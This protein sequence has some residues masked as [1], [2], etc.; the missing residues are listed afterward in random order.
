MVRLTF[1]KEIVE[2]LRKELAVAEKLNNLHLYKIVTCLL[3]IQEGKHFST[4]AKQVNICCRTVY[5]WLKK[6]MVRGFSWLLGKHYKG[7]GRKPQWH[8]LKE[9]HHSVK[10]PHQSIEPSQATGAFQINFRPSIYTPSIYLPASSIFLRK[11]G[12]VLFFDGSVKW[13]RQYHPSHF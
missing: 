10:D 8:S 7:R 1:E 5:D 13:S 2:R 3:L 11:S 12:Q 6:F 9:H 4:I